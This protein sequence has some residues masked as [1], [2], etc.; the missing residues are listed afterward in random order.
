MNYK[1]ADDFVIA[2]N[3]NYSVKE[4]INLTVKNLGIK[5][6]WTG[7]GLKE[8]AMDKNGKILIKIHKKLFRPSKTV[9]LSSNTNK[10]KK[11]L[12]YKV[13]TNLNKLITIMMKNDLK[14]EEQNNN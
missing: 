11:I 5:I 7:K 10:A 9:S 4:F 13:K 8:K 14:I 12:N 2:S 1:E 3:K 6:F